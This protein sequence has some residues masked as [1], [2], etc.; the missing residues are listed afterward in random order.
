MNADQLE[1]AADEQWAVFVAAQAAYIAAKHAALVAEAAML[2]AHSDHRAA[3][4]R[5]DNALKGKQE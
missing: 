4:V 5:L 1:K 2:A 3:Q